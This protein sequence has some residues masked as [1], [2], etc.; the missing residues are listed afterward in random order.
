MTIHEYQIDQK[1]LILKN[2]R[3]PLTVGKVGTIVAFISEPNPKYFPEDEPYYYVFVNISEGDST[4][5]VLTQSALI[6][7][8]PRCQSPFLKWVTWKRKHHCGNCGHSWLKILVSPVQVRFLAYLSDK[9]LYKNN[10]RANSASQRRITYRTACSLR[11]LSRC[12]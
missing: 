6:M 3:Q 2:D 7:V 10:Y 4:G 9:F 8:C 12:G 11:A 1:V 5:C